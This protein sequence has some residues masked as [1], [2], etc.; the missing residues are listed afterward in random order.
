[1]SRQIDL[2]YWT[3]KYTE[4]IVALVYVCIVRWPRVYMRTSLLIKCKFYTITCACK[5]YKVDLL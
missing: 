3:I 2:I 5:S 1:M 4:T